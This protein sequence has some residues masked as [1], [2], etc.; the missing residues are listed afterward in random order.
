M[1][2]LT[3]AAGVVG[4]A[5]RERHPDMPL[6]SLCH[7]RM[8][9]GASRVVAGD[10]TKPRAGLSAG[11]YRDLC[12]TVDTVVHCAA[13]VSFTAR[14]EEYETIN[15]DGTRNVVRLSED[16]NARLVHVSTAF[17]HGLEPGDE[18]PATY[19][20]SKLRAEQLVR[21][22]DVPASIVRPSIV[23]GDSQT[24]DIAQ[25]QGIYHAVKTLVNGPIRMVPGDAE[26]Y[27]DFVPQD[28]VADVV[29]AVAATPD[30]PGELWLTI[31]DDALRLGRFAELIDA[32]ARQQELPG[33][34]VRTVEYDRVE[35]LFL[36]I[37]PP[38]LQR[39]MR[40]LLR[41]ARYVNMPEPFPS[42]ADV[43]ERLYGIPCPDAMAV[44][45]VNLD[46]WWRR[47][48]TAV[49]TAAG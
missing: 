32:F 46:A 47:K 24:G 7:R 36:P 21:A 2:L 43:V 11:D 39:D 49:A 19:E 31:G 14:P 16:A 37:L 34:K 17:V 15:V 29:A 20:A 28:Y 25:E 10:V 45:D 1:I 3:G 35:R 38:D 33:E 22:S 26:M 13:T 30:A 9:N 23:V 8:L 27:I 18:P 6:V 5:I 12:T 42:S 44:F 40:T 41:L 48:A 4:S